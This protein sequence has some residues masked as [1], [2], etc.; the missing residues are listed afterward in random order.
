MSRKI[1]GWVVPQSTKW[2][3]VLILLTTTSRAQ[4]LPQK[5]TSTVATDLAVKRGARLSQIDPEARRRLGI[6]RVRPGDLG[7]VAGR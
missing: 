5:P 3:F 2:L 4:D 6:G 7:H 1:V